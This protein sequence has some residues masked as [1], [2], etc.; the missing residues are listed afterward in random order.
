MSDEEAAILGISP[1]EFPLLSQKELEREL[2]ARFPEYIDNVTLL[3]IYTKWLVKQV[4]YLGLFSHRDSSKTIRNCC[5]YLSSKKYD[6]GMVISAFSRHKSLYLKD[7]PKGI[8]TFNLA[9]R[10]IE[11]NYKISP[12]QPPKPASSHATESSDTQ[13][14]LAHQSKPPLISAQQTLATP[15]TQPSG[16]FC[17]ESDEPKLS[18]RQELLA[19]LEKLKTKN[20]LVN[21]IIMPSSSE[22]QVPPA[23]YI[24]NRCGIPGTYDD[25][26]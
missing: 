20:P 7:R 15:F 5:N 9:R 21:T 24:C 3:G 26:S 18:H 19:R 14:A 12:D 11:I 16:G 10:D 1:R 22:K 4:P 25:A 8:R 2:N 23:N 13:P 17:P 6:K